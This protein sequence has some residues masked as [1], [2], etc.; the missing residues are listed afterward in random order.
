MQL[1]RKRSSGLIIDSGVTPAAEIVF[2]G[3]FFRPF[4]QDPDTG[5]V[6]PTSELVGTD[7]AID[8][9]YPGATLCDYGPAKNAG[10]QCL[11]EPPVT[12]KATQAFW[13][14]DTAFQKLR[15]RG[16]NFLR[17]FGM[18]GTE[19]KRANSG[20]IDVYPFLR[21]ATTNKLQ[22]VTAINLD[23]FNFGYFTSLRQFVEQ[24]NQN[25]VAVQFCLFSFHD[26]TNINTDYFK[27]YP[28]APWNPAGTLSQ[29]WGETNL[30]PSSITDAVRR[31]IY[32]CDVSKAVL[33][34]QK[35]WISHALSAL[36]GLGNVVVEIF[37]EPRSVRRDQ[38][39]V[40]EDARVRLA[41]WYDE[42]VRFMLGIFS[43][44][45]WRPLISVNPTFD[46]GFNQFDTDIWK[47]LFPQSFAEVDLLSYH[48]L[49]GFPKVGA[50]P[51]GSSGQFAPVTPKHIRNRITAHQ[52][53][54]GDKGLIFSTDSVNQLEHVFDDS[55]PARPGNQLFLSKRDGQIRTS[56]SDD[57]GGGA[58]SV[59]VA[60]SDLENWAYWSFVEMFK[61]ENEVMVNKGRVHFQN[62]SI[63]RKSF[64][65][66]AMA[67]TK[68]M[69]TGTMARAAYTTMNWSQYSFLSEPNLIRN[70]VWAQR[71]RVA[72]GGSVTQ[73]G[74]QPT[75]Q[76]PRWEMTV[77]TGWRFNF[78][79]AA[80]GWGSF[81]VAYTPVSVSLRSNG[82]LVI[83]YVAARLAE[84]VS[85][86]L[87]PAFAQNKDV[88][89]PGARPAMLSVCGDLIA[90]KQY[91]LVFA[92][93]VTVSYRDRRQGNGEVI[94]DF[95]SV[96]GVIP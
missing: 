25:G 18:N 70:F 68:A 92:G 84:V 78:S 43:N 55:D 83:P 59:V 24:A 1:T 33:N 85:G 30:V 94:A 19:F 63:L 67:R 31:N 96:R 21:Q 82:A 4:V 41:T 36:S 49:T 37:N 17:V 6:T 87:R 48:G 75:Q 28:L 46:E 32:F 60:E 13:N 12:P 66:I 3:G 8:L 86:T 51:C 54:H 56:F 53:S 2:S 81:H 72:E 16:I 64:D 39:G 58:D 11:G 80:N 29:D 42:I 20:V 50:A 88:L 89:A 71:F 5:A 65:L 26:F 74:T 9:Q 23:T 47:Q 77:E 7:G 79:P 35:W 61:K 10:C 95:P 45:S 91:A 52:G 34:V 15:N 44:N 38:N 40:L 76:D 27:Y 93:G 73:L 62:H 22:V 57:D 90:H 69:D 14:F